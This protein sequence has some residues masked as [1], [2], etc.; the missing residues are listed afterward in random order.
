M[1]VEYSL[2][3]GFKALM[4]EIERVGRT[5]DWS[6]LVITI[7]PEFVRQGLVMCGDIVATGP[8]MTKEMVEAQIQIAIGERKLQDGM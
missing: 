2:N 8:K 7:S 5:P 3:R 6:T 4:D 1:A